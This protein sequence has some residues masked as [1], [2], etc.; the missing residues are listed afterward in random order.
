M[1]ATPARR[2]TLA[3]SEQ[4]ALAG[5]LLLLA[6]HAWPAAGS[7]LEYRHALIAAEPWRLL[8]AHLVHINWTH[9]LINAAAWVVVARLFAPDLSAA[10]QGLVLAAGAVAIGAG[11]AL[12]HPAIVWYRGFSGAL[13]ALFFAGATC[14]LLRDLRQPAER[15]WR[16]LWLPTLLVVGGWIKVITEQPAGSA[17]PFADWL[18]AGT[19]PQAHL[20]G[21]ACGAVLGAVFARRDTPEPSESTESTEPTEPSGPGQPNEPARPT[22]RPRD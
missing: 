10:R 8:S 14:W 4:I 13:H 17:T 22:A 5:A 16:A 18:G 7:A 2:F 19:V 15:H 11:L 12:L 9:A 6:L 3:R 21:A 20:I 1:N